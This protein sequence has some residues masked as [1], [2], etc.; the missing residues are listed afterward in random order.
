VLLMLDEIVN[1]S[2]ARTF[3]TI[4]KMRL[5]TPSGFCF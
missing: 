1:G 5:A 3:N 4:G 2:S